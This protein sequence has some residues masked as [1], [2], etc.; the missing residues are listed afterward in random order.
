MTS[1]SFLIL[2]IFDMMG[3]EP[4]ALCM[5]GQHSTTELHHS[6]QVLDI[7][8]FYHGFCLL[9]YNSPKVLKDHISEL[10]F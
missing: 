9:L 2:I 10:A 5:L 3:I 8:N 1:L 6:P 7:K 4:R